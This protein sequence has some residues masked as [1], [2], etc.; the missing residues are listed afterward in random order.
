MTLYITDY[1]TQ[2]FSVRSTACV[3]IDKQ[4]TSAICA[5][6]I[7]TLQDRKMNQQ[8]KSKKNTSKVIKWFLIWN[9]AAKTGTRPALSLKRM[10]LTLSKSLRHHLPRNTKGSFQLS[11]CHG[12]THMEEQY[13]SIHNTQ[14]AQISGS[15]YRA[16]WLRDM[17]AHG[18]TGKEDSSFWKQMP[19]KAPPDLLYSTQKALC[20]EQN[21]RLCLSCQL[22]RD[23][24]YYGSGTTHDI[25]A[26]R[27]QSCRAQYTAGKEEEGRERTG[28]KTS[29]NG[30]DS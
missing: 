8:N 22:G 26:C 13:L 12:M 15:F 4:R 21:W 2:T 16:V 27:K 24:N 17:D 30:P 6:S 28:M 9:W 19:E 18:C 10:S 29:K 7:I 3:F 5:H 25:A 14:T 1:H 11:T 23:A 20:L